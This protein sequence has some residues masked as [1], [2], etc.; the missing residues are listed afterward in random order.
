V[1]LPLGLLHLHFHIRIVLLLLLLWQDRLDE[2]GAKSA[3][4]A[5]AG[6]AKHH[7]HLY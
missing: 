5:A 7:R 2:E 3:T 6:V 1:L 4:A